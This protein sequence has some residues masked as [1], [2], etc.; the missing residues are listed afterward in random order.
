MQPSLTAVGSALTHDSR[1]PVSDRKG[2]R[3]V[4]CTPFRLT[5]KKNSRWDLTVSPSHSVIVLLWRVSHGC[6]QACVML[7][8][9]PT[10]VYHDFVS[11]IVLS[12]PEL[13]K[14]HILSS[15]LAR[16]HGAW[17]Q[18]SLEAAFLNIFQRGYSP[19]EPSDLKTLPYL[20]NCVMHIHHSPF[21]CLSG[22]YSGAHRSISCR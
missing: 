9:R 6:L 19:R 14:A 20:S 12:S 3:S 1:W 7:S 22:P 4:L 8:P 13:L 21:V 10:H 16:L 11:F 17:W 18:W 15:S 5:A 2:H